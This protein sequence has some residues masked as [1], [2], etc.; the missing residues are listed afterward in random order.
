MIAKVRLAGSY[1]LCYALWLVTAALGLLDLLALRQLVEWTYVAL[2][3]DKWGLA[4]A[5]HIA[6]IVFATVWLGVTIYAEQA[7]REGVAQHALW[8]RFARLTLVQAVP[9]AVALLVTLLRRAGV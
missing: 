2:A 5:S 4:A 3:L 1:V 8:R 9:L 7:Y 6:T